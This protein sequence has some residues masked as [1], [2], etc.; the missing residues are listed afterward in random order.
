MQ[1]IKVR[2]TIENIKGLG[3]DSFRLKKRRVNPMIW[4]WYCLKK[5]ISL[6][7]VVTLI[8]GQ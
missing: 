3:F 1:E 2:E 6:K 7:T 4:Q 5:D 8:G